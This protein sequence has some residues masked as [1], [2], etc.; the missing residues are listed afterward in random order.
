MDKAPNLREHTP[1]LTSPSKLNLGH[2][3]RVL[4]QNAD[5]AR[6]RLPLRALR[7]PLKTLSPADLLHPAPTLTTVPLQSALASP[8]R[9][10]GSPERRQRILELEQESRSEKKPKSVSMRLEPE[11]VFEG[12]KER[13]GALETA[14]KENTAL[15][16]EMRETQL[17]LLAE[18][19]E[20]KATV[21]D[22]RKG[23]KRPS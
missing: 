21:N 10:S 3:S 7:S 12:K 5:S 17:F 11:V 14:I 6:L 23:G 8:V 16:R 15:L 22:L 13:F 20:L 18:I 9:W 2:A 1:V 4:T 19:R